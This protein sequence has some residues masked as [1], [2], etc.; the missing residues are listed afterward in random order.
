MTAWAANAC[1][2][3]ALFS[4]ALVVSAIGGQGRWASGTWSSLT[5][6]TALKMRLRLNFTAQSF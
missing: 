4:L 1:L 5:H 6:L 2:C 3:S